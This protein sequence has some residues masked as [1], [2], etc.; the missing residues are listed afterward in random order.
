[1]SYYL[2]KKLST[3]LKVCYN[4]F[5]K[6]NF[7]ILKNQEEII[8]SIKIYYKAIRKYY[9]DIKIKKELSIKEVIKKK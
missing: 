3:Y 4:T 7:N 5:A 2:L 8:T 9:K 1:M 6:K